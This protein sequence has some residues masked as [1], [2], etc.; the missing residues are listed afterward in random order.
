MLDHIGHI[1][2]RALQVPIWSRSARERN[3]SRD[4][5]RRGSRMSR[6][7]VNAGHAPM[8]RRRRLGVCTRTAGW[9]GVSRSRP[10]GTYLVPERDRGE[11]GAAA[12]VTG[13]TTCFGGLQ[14]CSGGGLPAST[15]IPASSGRPGARRRALKTR[16]PSRRC[17]SRLCRVRSSGGFTPS[18]SA[19]RPAP[20]RAIR[21]STCRTNSGSRH[22]GPG[23]R[24]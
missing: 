1:A 12:G 11:E 2:T 16:L 24:C 19:R 5:N 3:G 15:V 18:R 22:D 20:H 6:Q 7:P 10:S 9:R 23:R 17:P 4:R 21:P 8:S 13:E 14:A